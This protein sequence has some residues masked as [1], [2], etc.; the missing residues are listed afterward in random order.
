MAILTKI[1]VL[2]LEG[3]YPGLLPVWDF[4]V[5]VLWLAVLASGIVR[6]V[7]RMVRKTRNFLYRNEIS[8]E[9][10]LTKHISSPLQQGSKT[11]GT[12]PI[13]KISS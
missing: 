4:L 3:L 9:R 2:V 12:V 13:A 10:D 5:T 8:S 7:P 6:E 1:C 11:C